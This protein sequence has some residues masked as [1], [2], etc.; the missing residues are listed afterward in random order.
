[1]EYDNRHG[2]VTLMDEPRRLREAAA[3]GFTR[4]HRQMTIL[5]QRTRVLES[6]VREGKANVRVVSNRPD[7]AAAILRPAWL[8]AL[9]P[10]AVAAR[11]RSL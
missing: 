11:R 6:E 2:D 4:S 1:V 10:L 3:A 5:R 7:R 8:L 9:M